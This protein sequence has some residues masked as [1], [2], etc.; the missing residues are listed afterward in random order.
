MSNFNW[1]ISTI[2]IISLIFRLW[3]CEF[4]LKEE[5]GYRRRYFS[6]ILALFFSVTMIYGFR[7]PVF[8]IISVWSIP[9]LVFAIFGWDT[10]FFKRWKA[11]K[12]EEWRGKRGWMLFERIT[13][14]IPM[15]IVTLYLCIVDFEGFLLPA[16]SII[17]TTFNGNPIFVLLF[18][19]VIVYTVYMLFDS[20]YVDR[21]GWP[22]GLRLAQIA[23]LPWAV[24][25]I[26]VYAF[27]LT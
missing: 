19:T 9:F 3:L 22:I 26:L 8:N 12:V 16:N 1:I 24:V 17:D 10:R 2:G 11:D 21:H 7:N 20:R 18:A 15:L 23:I 27:L 14:H 5:L 4:Y 6:R 25:Y 13:L